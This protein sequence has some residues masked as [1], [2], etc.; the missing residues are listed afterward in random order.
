M[1]FLWRQIRLTIIETNSMPGIK[2]LIP[3]ANKQFI[4]FN[5]RV[6]SPACTCY[7]RFRING[8]P[9]EVIPRRLGYLRIGS[10]GTRMMIFVST[11]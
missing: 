7:F 1:L 10:T 6:K 8:T 3:E 11:S 2:H 4:P 9:V 5:V